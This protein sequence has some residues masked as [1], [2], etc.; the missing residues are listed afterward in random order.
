MS[1]RRDSC[2]SALLGAR[3]NQ[4][5]RSDRGCQRWGL[6]LRAMVCARLCCAVGAHARDRDRAERERKACRHAYLTRQRHLECAETDGLI[7]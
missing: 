1:R 2:A 6:Q 5:Q 4:Y 7:R 3:A